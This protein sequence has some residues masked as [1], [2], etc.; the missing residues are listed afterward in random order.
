MYDQLMSIQVEINPISIAAPFRTAQTNPIETSC[1]LNVSHLN[2][3]MK[4]VL[5]HPGVDPPHCGNVGLAFHR[6]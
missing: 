3:K 1:F 2:G 5:N 6:H 4:W